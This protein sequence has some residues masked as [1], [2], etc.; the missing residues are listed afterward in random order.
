MVNI[1]DIPTLNKSVNEFRSLIESNARRTQALE[2]KKANAEKDAV[3]KNVDA[4][5]ELNKKLKNIGD[6]KK[7]AQLDLAESQQKLT[8][9]QEKLEK[10]NKTEEEIKKNTQFQ[11]LNL[12]VTKKTKAAS[13]KTFKELEKSLNEQK[14]SRLD[15]QKERADAKVR[16]QEL[17]ALTKKTLGI[18]E[19]RFQEL[20]VANEI[21]RGARLRLEDLRTELQSQ[22]IDVKENKNFQKL[23]AEVARKERA[24]RLKGKPLASS[25]LEQSKD[26]ARATG[27]QLARF[28]GP[29]SFF[30]KSIGGLLGSLNRRF[31]SPLTSGLSTI[32]KGGTLIAFLAGLLTFFKSPIWQNYKEYLIPALRNALEKTVIQLKKTFDD[33]FGKDGGFVKGFDG[34]ME[35]LFGVSPDSELNKGLK[36]FGS[37]VKRIFFAFF[38]EPGKDGKPGGIFVGLKQLGIELLAAAGLVDATTGEVLS[39]KEI[40]SPNNPVGMVVAIAGLVTGLRLVTKLI[41]GVGSL[42]AVAG[43]FAGVGAGAAGAGA[44]A[45]T[46]LTKAMLTKDDIIRSGGREFKLD[47]GGNLKLFDRAT[48]TMKALES[49]MTEKG[50]LE[51]AETPKRLQKIPSRAMKFLRFMGGLAKRL[52]GLGIGLAVMNI[53]DAFTSGA[54]PAE[55]T[56]QIAGALGGLGGSAA[57]GMLVGGALGT[58]GFPVIG[59]A[60]GSAGG[61]IAGYFAGDAMAQGLAEFIMGKSVTAFS[62]IED[63]D[64]RFGG[65]NLN[66]LLSTG[67]G[68]DNP[69]PGSQTTMTQMTGSPLEAVGVPK[70]IP[71]GSILAVPEVQTGLFQ[72]S[73]FMFKNTAFGRVDMGDFEDLGNVP[74]GVSLSDQIQLKTSGSSG[75]INQQ[76]ISSNVNASTSKTISNRN[77]SSNGNPIVDKVNRLVNM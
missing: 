31:I 39:L 8:D 55:M 48:G 16:Q 7:K 25:L 72:A 4:I 52:P 49:G 53:V 11:K 45:A 18:N 20:K 6:D 1:P 50:I 75:S 51:K 74:T 34:I 40:F 63:S 38:G 66:K 67:S 73:N 5:K 71:K 70:V 47:K 65:L 59:T 23:E 35:D 10:E 33:F 13:D 15:E 22:S 76:L 56:K 42:L 27:K 54:S 21:A 46:G 17:K 68:E 41:R 3:K 30:G 64:L 57:L 60:I 26:A 62:T 69:S 37:S 43:G 61:A 24:A 28:L 77:I 19:D 58:L 9:L 14:Q 36:R 44:A 29:N 2:V 32:L 12:E